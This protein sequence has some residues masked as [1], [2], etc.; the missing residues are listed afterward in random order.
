MF[1]TMT[2][3]NLRNPRTAFGWH[4]R[5]SFNRLIGNRFQLTGCVRRNRHDLAFAQQHGSSRSKSAWEL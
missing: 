5:S 1:V 4:P 2:E 3:E